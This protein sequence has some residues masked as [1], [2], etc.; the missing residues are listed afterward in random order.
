MS[1]TV[2]QIDTKEGALADIAP[3]KKD[4]ISQRILSRV[5]S[6]HYISRIPGERALAR[7][8]GVDVK[9]VNRAVTELVNRGLLT[10][11]RGRGTYVVGEQPRV[12]TRLS[13]AFFKFAVEAPDPL[14]GDLFVSMNEEA[15]DCGCA[16]R[17]IMG[18][19]RVPENL[20][21]DDLNRWRKFDSCLPT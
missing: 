13:L 12:R 4:M 14:F 11:K 16:L 18:S 10:R 7:E 17:L 19:R 3:T 5:R 20:S 2:D 9:T 15:E 8:F 6:G 21:E 1:N